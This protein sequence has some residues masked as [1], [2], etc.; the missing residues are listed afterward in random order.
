MFFTERSLYKKCISTYREVS[1]NVHVCIA[2]GVTTTTLIPTDA[3]VS[4]IGS[5]SN[6]VY[7]HG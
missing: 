1:P 6:F 7:S 3:I 5:R 4:S 2:V